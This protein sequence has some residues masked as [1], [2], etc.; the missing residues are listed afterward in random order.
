MIE[1]NQ[2]IFSKSSHQDMDTVW[3]LLLHF[4]WLKERQRSHN[5]PSVMSTNKIFCLYIKYKANFS[6]VKR[7]ASEWRKFT[8]KLKNSI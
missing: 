2:L 1:H 4:I 6:E 3:F 7:K 8:Q 5:A